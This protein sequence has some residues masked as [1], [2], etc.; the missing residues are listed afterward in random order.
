MLKVLQSSDQIAIDAWDGTLTYKELHLS[1]SALA[2]HLVQLGADTGSLIP[3]MLEKSRWAVVTM[4]AIWKSGAAYVPLDPTQPLDRLLGLLKQIKPKIVIGG[5]ITNRVSDIDSELPDTKIVDIATL[6]T[7][8]QLASSASFD[9]LSTPT[10]VAYVLFT[11]GST[12]TPKGVVIEHQSLCVSLLHLRDQLNMPERSKMLQFSAFIWDVH[13]AEIWGGLISGATVC[14]P[15]EQ[16]RQGNL[17]EYMTSADIEIAY[18]TPTVSSVVDPNRVSALK[19]IIFVGEALTGEV[20]T[21]WSQAHNGAID[22]L[23]GYGPTET[24]FCSLHPGPMRSQ[25]QENNIGTGLGTSLW[26][27]NPANINELAPVGCPGELLVAGTCVA[28]GYLNDEAR[29][30]ERFLRG[31]PWMHDWINESRSDFRRI[32]K[33]GDI[34]RYNLDGTLTYLGRKDTQTK[35]NGQRI[36]PGEIEHHVR[37]GMAS[38]DLTSNRSETAVLIVQPQAMSSHKVL[39]AFLSTNLDL[40]SKAIAGVIR[41]IRKYLESVLPRYMVPNIFIPVDKISTTATGKVDRRKLERFALTLSVDELTRFSGAADTASGRPVRTDEEKQLEE[42]WRAV[43]QSPPSQFISAE[44][45]FFELG[46]DSVLCMKLMSLANKKGLRLGIQDIWEFPVLEQMAQH[47]Q[48]EVSIPIQDAGA[49]YLM[50]GWGEEKKQEL[51]MQAASTCGTN[52][53]EIEDIL[54]CTSMQEALLSLSSMQDGTYIA[55]IVLQ[56]PPTIDLER[57][58]N[59]VQSVIQTHQILRTR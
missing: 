34:V 23:N 28:R 14:I 40:Q 42:L 49:F 52:P 24:G 35:V 27:V 44:D 41:E 54:P 46:G 16:E 26:V 47:V 5:P 8:N 2:E 38:L 51:I 4:L 50:A 32:Y 56:L 30:T 3:I 1:S 43:L 36:E 12:G 17:E 55:S 59:A 15:S 10:N 13:A 7:N 18:L 21:K 20:I 19:K 48:R 37:L 11:S 29:T 39:A 53:E 25:G 6:P 57:L 31:L 45:N 9:S 33:T 22:V 58:R